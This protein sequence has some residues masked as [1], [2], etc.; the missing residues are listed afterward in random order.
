L[1][2]F[3]NTFSIL[4][5][6]CVIR[7]DKTAWD[8]LTRDCSIPPSAS[9]PLWT[10]FSPK[11]LSDEGLREAREL[12]HYIPTLQEFKL[13][14]NTL[15]PRSAAGFSG[16]SYLMVQFWPDL[17]VER[18]YECLREAWLRK[19]GL[20]GWGTRLLAPIPKKPNPELKDLRPLML[21]EV[22]RKI[23]VGLITSK[24]TSF[25]GKHSLIDAKQHAYLKGKG[26]QTAIPQI[27]NAL[28]TAREYSTD[29][30]ISSWDMSKAFDNLSREMILL[31][32]LR[33]HIPRCIA[34]YLI[35][36]D[37]D[38]KVYVRTPWLLEKLR[39]AD[40]TLSP[41][42]CFYTEKGVGQGDI[43][44]PLLWIAA[45]DIPLVA[46][47]S[48]PSDFRVQDIACQV[49]VCS[50]VAYADDLVSIVATPEKLQAKADVMSAWCL[51]SNVNMNVGKLRTF[52]I[53][54]GV[55]KGSCQKLAINGDGEGWSKVLVDINH[56]GIMTHLGVVW[57]MDANND[58]QFEM[59]K[60]TL[61]TLG[62]R[63]LRHRGRVGDKLLE[64]EYCLRSNIVYRM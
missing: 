17:V 8:V 59:L 24:I 14:I 30:Y 18:A 1:G 13:H 25:L 22:M 46:L 41:S 34:E 2:R 43:P 42:D 38:G 20:E 23:W 29:L 54:W 58:K 35:S 4:L 16:L 53:L 45:F 10:A 52:G 47:S 26:T 49:A 62:A 19:E 39:S 9:E 48:I 6:D 28:E 11:P 15:N 63:I 37:V 27:I 31:S 60:E 56:D 40:P 33:L 61:E 36:L 7:K 21:V 12:E 44:S 50:D 55:D 32:L 3:C 64:L 5:A 57:N 51:L